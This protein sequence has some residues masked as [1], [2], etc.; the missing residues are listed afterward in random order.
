[1]VAL[2]YVQLFPGRCLKSIRLLPFY[3][4]CC[5]LVIGVNVEA[6]QSKG[7]SGSNGVSKTFGGPINQPK[8]GCN[9]HIIRCG[10]RFCVLYVCVCV[11]VCVDYIYC[12]AVPGLPSVCTVSSDDFTALK[13]LVSQLKFSRMGNRDTCNP[14]CVLLATKLLPGNMTLLF[15]PALI[16]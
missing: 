12:M 4:G 3:Q 10:L 11:C 1:M 9:H 8:Q 14:C 6:I 2:V 7:A 13:Y 16:W 5:P 15:R